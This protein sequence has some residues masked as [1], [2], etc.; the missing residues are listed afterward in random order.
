M[1]K[2]YFIFLII[3]SCSG[4]FAQMENDMDHR[5]GGEIQRFFT[6]Q[7]FVINSIGESTDHWTS[8]KADWKSATG[9][10]IGYVQIYASNW[11]LVYQTGY[12]SYKYNEES[13]FTGD[14]SYSVIPLAIGG[15]YYLVRHLF[16]PYLL[17]MTGLNIISE[18]YTRVEGEE[19]QVTDKTSG[20]LH[21]QVGVGVGV[22]VTERIGL[23]ISGKYNSHVLEAP[24]PYNMTGLE[25]G[26]AINWSL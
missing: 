5:P 13:N 11:A 14:P 22:N 15:R 16:Q 10:S 20:R 2:Q 1:K 7:G 26:L 17:A 21:F 12:F 25:Y 9:F 4:L 3:F 24:V 23:E 19:T 8:F 18:K 6:L